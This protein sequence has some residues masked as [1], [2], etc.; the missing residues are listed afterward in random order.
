MTLSR[1]MAFNSSSNTK[2]RFYYFHY[3]VWKWKF[4]DGKLLAHIHPEMKQHSSRDLLGSE[5][6]Q[7]TP[8]HAPGEV[9]D[10]AVVCFWYFSFS[11]FD[12]LSWMPACPPC[13]S[14][15]VMHVLAQAL[16]SLFSA[17]LAPS[18]MHSQATKMH[19]MNYLG[20][21]ERVL[22]AC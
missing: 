5:S 21:Q 17:C 20:S 22:V 12:I 15:P 2:G 3:M 1:I 11:R 14:D 16:H 6:Q 18:E 8:S 13:C 7:T 9:L 19:W 10:S 4:R